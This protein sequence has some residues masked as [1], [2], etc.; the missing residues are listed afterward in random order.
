MNINLNQLEQQVQEL[1]AQ[2][3]RFPA[4]VRLE[5]MKLYNL[6]PDAYARLNPQEIRGVLPGGG[7]MG[8]PG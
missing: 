7:F 2:T 3:G 5:L 4:D 6:T 8:Q 1:S